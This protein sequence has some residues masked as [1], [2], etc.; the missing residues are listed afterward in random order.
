M[1]LQGICAE[2]GKLKL[3]FGAADSFLH[4]LFFARNRQV[5]HHEPTQHDG[6]G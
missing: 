2:G 3:P 5:Q 1:A 6:N 4:V